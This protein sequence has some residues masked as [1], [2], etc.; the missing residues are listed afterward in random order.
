MEA[1]YTLMHSID[2]LSLPCDQNPLVA[3]LGNLPPG[4]G[5]SLMPRD[6]IALQ[7]YF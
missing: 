5:A 1:N 6:Q 2:C 7:P 4:A 3:R